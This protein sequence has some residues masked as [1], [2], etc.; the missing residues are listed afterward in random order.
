VQA[1]L[2][3]IRRRRAREVEVR[4]A[5]AAGLEPE[6][7]RLLDA[8]RISISRR[9]SRT[10]SPAISSVC[11]P[12]S[13]GPVVSSP[14][15]RC[16]TPLSWLDASASIARRPVSR[17]ASSAVQRARRVPK[18]RAPRARGRASRPRAPRAR[19]AASRDARG[20]A[21]R[22]GASRAGRHPP[23]SVPR[24][25]RATNERHRR[26]CSCHSCSSTPLT[27]SPSGPTTSTA[28][29]PRELASG[30]TSSSGPRP[31]HTSSTSSSGKPRQ[32]SGSC[33]QSRYARSAR[34]SMRKRPSASVGCERERMERSSA[35]STTTTA[36]ATGEPRS[37][38]IRPA[39]PG[40][41]RSATSHSKVSPGASTTLALVASVDGVLGDERH[42]ARREAVELE[43]A[44]EVRP[45]ARAREALGVAADG[46]TRSGAERRRVR[47]RGRWRAPRAGARSR[48]RRSSPGAP[49]T[50]R[51]RHRSRRRALESASVRAG[52][53]RARSGPT[54][55]WSRARAVPRARTARR[56]G[57]ASTRGPRR[58][59]GLSRRERARRA[60]PRRGRAGPH[61][62]R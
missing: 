42:R 11:T 5:Q 8:A 20:G 21:A 47:A 6:V 39:M 3:H 30:T 43:A 51:R 15:A 22:G 52:R 53:S 26:R 34:P 27:L 31:G 23:R 32:P 10:K 25:P 49:R 9:T 48:A 44:V 40:S 24:A 59:R 50:R 28:R 18:A 54:G 13:S 1:A 2:H 33:T 58:R 38:T 41:T 7:E 46:S 57:G 12:G 45:R 62:R 17:C 56:R 19:R 37:S 35:G 55:R 60:R 4:L 16:T 29:R 36:P 14:A 61:P